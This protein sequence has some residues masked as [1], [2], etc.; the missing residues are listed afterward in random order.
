MNFKLFDYMY[1]QIFINNISYDSL[2]FLHLIVEIVSRFDSITVQ[3]PAC[4]FSI[5]FAMQNAVEV[6]SVQNR[7]LFGSKVKRNAEQEVGNHIPLGE[8]AR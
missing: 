8:G 4:T 7:R 2:F 6:F 3:I 1:L 5:V